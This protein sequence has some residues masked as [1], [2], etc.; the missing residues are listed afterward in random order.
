MTAAWDTGSIPFLETAGLS[1]GRVGVG[2][3]GPA[4]LKPGSEGE[5][6]TQQ[7]REKGKAEECHSGTK[8]PPSLVI[9]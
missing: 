9:D 3:H 5:P 2:I 4:A 7:Y 1:R 6:G 8:K